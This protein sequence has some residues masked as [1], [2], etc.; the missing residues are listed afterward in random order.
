NSN[1]PKI[2]KIITSK[3]WI[4]PPRPKP[5]RKPSIDTP[6]TK[7]KAQ[8]R[9]AQRAFRERR[10]NRVS[11][12]ET[13]ILELE[14]EKS[15]KEGIL[16]NTIKGLQ[17]QNDSLK[18]SIEEMRQTLELFQNQ[19]NG[20][21]P[22]RRRQISPAPS[23]S[24]NSPPSGQFVS[25]R[26]GRIYEDEHN[27]NIDEDCGICEK[28]DCICETVGLK[29]R[30]TSAVVF[31]DFEPAAAV[32]LKR[33]RP[34]EQE[35]D[36]TNT[37]TLKKMKKLPVFKSSKSQDHQN[38]LLFKS[39]IN[40]DL[41]DASPPQ[42]DVTIKREYGSSFA[43]EDQCGFCSDDTP[44]VCR[45]I[46]KQKELV[47]IK[48]SMIT[49]Q[50]NDKQEKTSTTRD[51]L[52]SEQGNQQDEQTNKAEGK[53]GCSGNPGSCRQCQQDPIS[54]L[55]CTT[56]AQQLQKPTSSSMTSL[57]ALGD[58]EINNPGK[59]FIPC[60][61]AYKTLSRHANFRTA[62]FNNIISNLNTKGMY[63]EVESV[64]NCLRQLDRKF[65]S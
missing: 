35:I 51:M 12:L 23:N 41:H 27:K 32:P 60:A 46:A 65:G 39:P 20:S 19:L 50:L 37:F 30:K 63:V 6:A 44:C 21:K 43:P 1:N 8:N 14:R 48:D 22:S 49:N 15:V 57:P 40:L 59:H 9:A 47:Q 34:I 45:E 33:S 64:V 56:I 61:D 42:N 29:N 13:Q 11:E 2:T 36:F 26:F 31:D 18:K 17:N 25:G 53:D 54:T 52:Q 55:F 62:G 5:G 38:D 16:T 58:L 4:L 28:D 7:R 10:A 3:Q 24:S